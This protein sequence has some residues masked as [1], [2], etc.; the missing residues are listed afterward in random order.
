MADLL[1]QVFL[2]LLNYFYLERK[3]LEG[4]I[5]LKY[6]CKKCNAPKHEELFERDPITWPLM[7]HLVIYNLMVKY[8]KRRFFKMKEDICMMVTKY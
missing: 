8:P 2:F 4:D 6:I 7:I 5:Y 3:I 1:L